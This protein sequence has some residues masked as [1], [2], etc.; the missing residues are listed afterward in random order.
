MS[1]QIGDTPTRIFN[2]GDVI[3]REG[4]DAKGEAFI[5]HSGKVEIRLRL[6]G[7]KQLVTVLEK[8]GASGRIRPLPQGVSLGDRHCC[9]AGDAH[10]TPSR[11]PGAYGPQ[12]S[13]AGHGYRA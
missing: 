4:D 9:R 7:E 12:Q 8:G 10:G 2:P 13:P 3:F 11:P 1:R 5:V 6:A